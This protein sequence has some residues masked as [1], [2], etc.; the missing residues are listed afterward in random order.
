MA[1]A[2]C[3]LASDLW[4]LTE[5]AEA[6]E[7]ELP[8]LLRLPLETRGDP[9][10]AAW[11]R[12]K[13]DLVLDRGDKVIVVD[14]KTDRVLSPEHYTVQMDLY[15]RAARAIYDKP[16]ESR[17]YHLRSGTALTVDVDIDDDLL[18]Q[19]VVSLRRVEG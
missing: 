18:E 11:V 10:D 13:M 12:G 16:A 14:F 7:F 4:K 9:S 5:A 17:L 15:R 8:F 6:Y 19:L 3:F 2:E 1:L